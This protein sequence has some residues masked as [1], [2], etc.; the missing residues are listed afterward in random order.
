MKGFGHKNL[1]RIVIDV[2]A[3]LRLEGKHVLRF[4]SHPPTPDM[5]PENN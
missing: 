5:I 4:L 3:D 1:T 2:C